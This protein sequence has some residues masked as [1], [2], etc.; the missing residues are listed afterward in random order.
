MGI[1]INVQFIIKLF[2]IQVY[3]YLKIVKIKLIQQQQQT[4]QTNKQ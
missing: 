4:K 2:I 1:N 3:G